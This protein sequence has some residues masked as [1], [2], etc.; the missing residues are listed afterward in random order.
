LT[1]GDFLGNYDMPEVV[2]REPEV[3]SSGPLWNVTVF[4]DVFIS[5]VAQT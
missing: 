2:F 4:F 5:G 3:A 1:F